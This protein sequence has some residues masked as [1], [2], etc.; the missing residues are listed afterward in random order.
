MFPDFSTFFHALWSRDPF[1]WQTMLAERVLK[2]AWPDAIDLPTASG[3]TAC[4]DIAVYA[5]AAQSE[6]PPG[7]R[8]AARRIWFVVDRRIVVDEAYER[9]QRVAAALES[10]DS[11]AVRAVADRLLGLRGLDS[12]KCPLAVGRL[13]DGVLRDDGWARIPSQAAIITSTVDQLGSR[14]LFRGY[15]HSTLAAPV[16]AGLAGNDSLILLDEAHC[17]VPF[18]QTL[19]AVEMFRSEKWSEEPNNTPLHITVLSATLPNGEEEDKEPTVFPANEG[20]RVKAL[21]HPVLQSRLTA[22]KRAV[23]KPV[24]LEERLATEIADAAAQFARDSTR[25]V[26]VIVNRVARAV[27]IEKLLRAKAREKV[28]EG[29]PPAFDVELLTGRIRPIERDEVV[30][31]LHPQL[32]S[33]STPTLARSLILVSTQCLEVGA[34]F[35]FDALVTECA[36]LDALRQRFGRLARLGKPETSHAVILA[37]ESA[38]KESDPKGDPIYGKALKETWG[39]LWRIAE[40][41]SRTEG[42]KAVEERTVDFGFESLRA[43]LPP[44]D[45]D[46]LH[47]ML[48]PSSDAPILL[49][50]HLDLLC[51][52]APR[53]HPDP[54]ISIFLHGKGHK[55]AEVRVAFRCDLDPDLSGDDWKEIVSLCP[56]VAGEMLSVP[57]HHFRHWLQNHE[58]TDCSGDV[59]GERDEEEEPQSR[60]ASKIK[61]LL[62][63]GRQ[64]SKVSS[65]VAD[66][67][68]DSIIILPAPRDESGLDEVRKLGQLPCEKGLGSQGADVWELAMQSAG[69]E[70]VLRIHRECLAPWLDNCPPLRALLDL[71]ENGGWLADELRDALTAVREWTP[72]DE[73][74]PEL[75]SWLL[76]L[77]SDTAHLGVKDIASL[78]RGGIILRVRKPDLACDETDYFSDED[79]TPSE[80]PDEVPLAPH[81]AQ[82]ATAAAKLAHACLGAA[83]A[84][85]ARIAGEW[86]D[87]GKLDPRFQEVLRNGAAADATAQPL[88]KSPRKPR[89]RDRT[90]EIRDAAGLPPEFR[91]EM[92]S[93]QLAERFCKVE[94]SPEDRE[95]LLHLVAS[96]HGHA[97]PF[98]PV[99]DDKE[100]PAVEGRLN[101]GSLVLSADER[102]AL[103]APH[104]LDSGVTDRFWLLTRRFGW[105]GLAYREAILRLA[106]WYASAHSN[107][108][109]EK[110]DIHERTT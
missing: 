67:F 40:V 97:R 62:W 103:T 93:M 60:R 88:A 42:K 101:S 41:G 64:E 52:T 36:S 95:L 9:A 30:G 43:L 94:L 66:V 87:A 84:A 100:P 1:P 59:E 54:D 74:R 31:R 44:P 110:G 102:E 16:Y 49:P 80:A 69:K 55:S 46:K 108:S 22:S 53:P 27:D 23:L 32:H 17:A 73:S 26:G 33:S 82:V 107:S 65:E 48:A 86:H 98:A 6:K 90:R 18:L 78:P 5:L 81:C 79:D 20:E 71:V 92:L 37:S 2:G 7:R 19:R 89:S 76:K 47:A 45:S 25:R 109:S 105:W 63:R 104:R 11:P 50:A 28:S 77:F 91:H 10:A 34:D 75:P 99:C 15:G 106:D 83:D 4:L 85:I 56:P 14:L 24:N 29:E 35:S 39:F 21:N 13:R 70:P 12:K 57:L 51:Q 58:T 61:F 96:H 68:P 72:E 8:T 38:L 3:K